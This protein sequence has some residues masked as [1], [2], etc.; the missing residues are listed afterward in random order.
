MLVTFVQIAVHWA[1]SAVDA[2]RNVHEGAVN[3]HEGAR[4]LHPGILEG[5]YMAVVGRCSHWRSSDITVLEA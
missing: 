4:K 1:G 5:A 3:V 2:V